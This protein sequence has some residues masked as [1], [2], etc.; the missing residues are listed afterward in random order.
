MRKNYPYLNDSDFMYTADLQR[1]QNQLIKITLLDWDENPLQE[2]QGIATGGSI[3]LNGNSAIRRTCNLNMIVKNVSD[4]QISD[5]KNFISINKKIFLEIGIVNK[6]GQYEQE[7]PILWYPQG[8]LVITSCSV[9]NALGQGTTLSAQFKDKIC[10]LN[11]ECGGIL[12]ASIRFD[13]W[14]TVDEN[15]EKILS[16]PTIQ[17][18]IRELVNHW[19]N[20]QLGKILISDIDEK[21]KIVM[22]WIGNYPVYLVNNSGNYYLT[23]DKES[24]P[25]GAGYTSYEY[26]SDIGFTYT[27]FVWPT[28]WGELSNNA[29]DNICTILEKIKKNDAEFHFVQINP[30]SIRRMHKY[31]LFEGNCKRGISEGLNYGIFTPSLEKKFS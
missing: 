1:L 16:K 7:Y 13:Q 6:T 19:G 27:D 5:I 14:D 24:I 2:I 11:G 23:M 21:A 28:S 15:G 30:I 3:S 17:Q 12:P 8:V 29:G 9:S 20:E 22:R 10:L 4:G 18:I 31:A 26:G 25:T